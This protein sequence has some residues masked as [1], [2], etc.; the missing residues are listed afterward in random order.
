MLVI[1]VVL[2]MRGRLVDDGYFGRYELFRFL[3]IIKY[4]CVSSIFINKLLFSP[5]NH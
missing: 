1:L 2:L 5:I 4:F 3:M